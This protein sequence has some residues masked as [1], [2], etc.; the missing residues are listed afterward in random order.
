M[1][2]PRSYFNPGSLCYFGQMTASATHEL[3]NCLA[4]I[5]EHAGLL[6]DLTT[7]SRN[8]ADPVYKKFEKISEKTVIQVK[9]ADTIL[10]NLNRFAH[11]AD[12]D[13]SQT[14]DLNDIISFVLKISGRLIEI[15]C[16][17]IHFIPLA[18][19]VI[20]D[21]NPFVLQMII[22]RS[23]EKLIEKMNGSRTAV[24]LLEKDPA[25]CVWFMHETEQK[26]GIEIQAPRFDESLLQMAS[27][28]IIRSPDKNGFGFTWQC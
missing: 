8:S 28:K 13:K 19:P 26:D 11:S 12:S 27:I 17:N 25:P 15:K 9:R 7:F 20:I 21:A 10:A 14:L 1:N 2:K 6:K 16:V 4:I 3:K 18:E 5:N 24:I 23:I 22:W